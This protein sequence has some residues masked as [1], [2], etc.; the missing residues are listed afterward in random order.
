MGKTT[1]QTTATREFKYTPIY[2]YLEYEDKWLATVD[3]S[4]LKGRNLDIEKFSS[5]C[6]VVQLLQEQNMFQTVA[7]A[8][9]FTGYTI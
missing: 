4:I 3:S 6:Q 9:R 1:Q 7:N 8:R 5:K 2:L